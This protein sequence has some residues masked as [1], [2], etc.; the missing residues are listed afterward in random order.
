MEIA[1]VQYKEFQT[2]LLLPVSLLGRQMLTKKLYTHCDRLHNQDPVSVIQVYLL[3]LLLCIVT[4]INT[5]DLSNTGLVYTFRTQWCNGGFLSLIGKEKTVFFP[6]V[7]IFFLRFLNSTMHGQWQW[8]S[9][10]IT[11]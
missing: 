9:F 7:L 11:V 2:T 4:A 6:V 8:A 3:L 10:V 1:I 5:H